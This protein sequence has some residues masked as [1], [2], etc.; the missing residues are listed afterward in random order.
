MLSFEIDI[1]C[2][3]NKSRKHK[4]L[5]IFVTWVLWL[6]DLA[7][8]WKMCNLLK[9]FIISGKGKV[10][11]STVYRQGWRN[12]R[13]TYP[14]CFC[15][16]RTK[17]SLFRYS[18]WK[19]QNPSQVIKDIYVILGQIISKSNKYPIISTICKIFV[20]ILRPQ[21]LFKVTKLEFLKIRSINYF[22]T[23][24]PFLYIS[25]ITYLP[26]SF[27]PKRKFSSLTF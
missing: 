26:I 24:L 7:D 20:R 14:N 21:Q 25:I 13:F 17:R 22:T 19:F 6:C 1:H 3:L 8:I 15:W 4:K 5:L 23:T 18:N 9:G 10:L 16:N 2:R 27:V 12:R 11:K